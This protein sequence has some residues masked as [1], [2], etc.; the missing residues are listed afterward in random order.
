MGTT[1]CC[2]PGLPKY[3]AM[4]SFIQILIR[5]MHNELRVELL[6]NYITKLILPYFP[7]RFFCH[8]FICLSF[9]SFLLFSLRTSSILTYST[10][11]YE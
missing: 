5:A 2:S 9:C 1:P 11:G 3:L 4:L 7:N 6:R 8:A 10:N